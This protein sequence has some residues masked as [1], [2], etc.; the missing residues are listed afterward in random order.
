MA[1]RTK[2]ATPKIAQ[3]ASGKTSVAA[4][5]VKKQKPAPAEVPA[6]RYIDLRTDFGFKHIFGDKEFLMNFL[7]A[8]LKIEGGIVDLWSNGC[9]F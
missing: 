3:V 4:A 7:N 2:T 8:V 1:K 5:T 9:M 6:G